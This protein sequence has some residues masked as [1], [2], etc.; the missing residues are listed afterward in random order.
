[1]DANPKAL[2]SETALAG[3][4]EVSL[5]DDCTRLVGTCPTC[6]SPLSA[7][8]QEDGSHRRMISCARCRGLY[9]IQGPAHSTCAR[10]SNLRVSYTVDGEWNVSEIMEYL[11]DNVGAVE[12]VEGGFVCHPDDRDA[13]F[14]LIGVDER[15]RIV[16]FELFGNYRE[17]DA[18]VPINL[19]VAELGA[20]LQLGLRPLAL[21]RWEYRGDTG[22]FALVERRS[23]ETFR[24]DCTRRRAHA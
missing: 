15:S 11:F 4:V 13:D 2:R 19:A 9:W 1:V 14:P 17:S 5:S 8:V 3:T 7:E 10:A 6:A 16:R 20:R 18:A 21:D 23:L 24:R 22:G 12:Y